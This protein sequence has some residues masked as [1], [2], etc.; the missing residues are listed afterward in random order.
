MIKASALIITIVL[1]LSCATRNE[2]DKTRSSIK[3]FSIEPN[4][5]I[6]LLQRIDTCSVYLLYADEHIIESRKNRFQDIHKNE[7]IKFYKNGR[8]GYFTNIV[9]NDSTTLNGKKAIMGLY[10]EQ[11]PLYMEFLSRSP[12]RGVWI[13]KEQITYI[14]ANNDTLVGKELENGYPVKYI[15]KKITRPL[16]ATTPDW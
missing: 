10:K 14:S 7:G 6:T 12:Q 4:D 16:V 3:R 13:W 15:R 2:Y 5:N 11:N 9:F 1:T 8:I